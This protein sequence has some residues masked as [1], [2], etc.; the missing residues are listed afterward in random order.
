MA[1]GFELV[2]AEL[3]A[4]ASRLDGI[5]DQ[6]NTALAAAR[7]VSLPTGAYGVICQFFPP[8]VDPVEQMGMDAIGEA[9]TAMEETATEIRGTADTYDAVDDTNRQAF[10]S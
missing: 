3:R 5:R 1:D 10:R 6:L 8:M 2:T 9:V 7:T 4:H